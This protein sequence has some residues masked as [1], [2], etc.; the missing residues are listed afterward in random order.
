[1]IIF[2]KGG[3]FRGKSGQ[4]DPGGVQFGRFALQH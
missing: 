4:K 3:H 2:G 1:M